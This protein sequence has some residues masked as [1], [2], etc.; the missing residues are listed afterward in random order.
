MNT[1]QHSQHAT[2]TSKTEAEFVR[3]QYQ[4]AI[5]TYRTQLS[6]L[7]QIITV[8]VLADATVAGYAITTQIASVWLIGPLFP[9][10]ILVVSVIVF[11]LMAPILLTAVSIEKRYQADNISWLA[12][13]FISAAVSPQYLNQLRDIS[14]ITDAE[15]VT[16]RLNL[17]PRPTFSATGSR[18]T[19]IA[20]VVLAA[21]QVLVALACWLFLGWRLY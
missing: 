5:E 18:F 14:Y 8:L 11:R 16:R 20:L 2:Q 10:M 17:L 3:L 21:G 4:Q 9:I 1:S 15:E 13:T 12:S 6:L 7:V 19:W